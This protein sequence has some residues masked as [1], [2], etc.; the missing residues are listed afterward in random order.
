MRD[1]P[2]SNTSDQQTTS[3][4]R[5]LAPTPMSSPPPT[6]PSAPTPRAAKRSLTTDA[7][8]SPTAKRQK[9]QNKVSNTLP[10]S[11]GKFK[12][13][14][15]RKHSSLLHGTRSDGAEKPRGLIVTCPVGAETRALGQ[16]RTFLDTYL[17]ILFPDHVTVWPSQP[18]PLDIDLAIV[19]EGT[20]RPDFYG[21]VENSKSDVRTGEV[22]TDADEDEVE[23]ER[24]ADDADRTV[25]EGKGKEREKDKKFQAVD[26][27]CAGL[28]F[29]RFRVDTDPVDFVVRLFEHIES[30]PPAEQAALKKGISHCS[31]L[32]PVTHTMPSTYPD[33]RSHLQSTLPTLLAAHQ[34]PQSSP[35]TIPTLAVI[36]EIRNHN[37]FKTVALRDV[38]LECVGADALAS[39]SKTEATEEGAQQPTSGHWKISLTNPDV[40]IFA[41]VFKS[42][43]GVAVLP[44]YFAWRRYNV[45]LIGEEKVRDVKDGGKEGAGK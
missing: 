2:L 37:T 25:I 5:T 18:A 32:L 3:K 16:I 22:D 41:N 23:D 7:P 36:S 21:A 27:A 11:R 35:P 31:R 9:K 30:L 15:L 14:F 6:R 26:A 42:V 43:C 8:T 34:P 28:I 44:R 29:I 12:N 4:T 13:R 40:V 24:R 39:E 1:L 10:I 38:I 33:I 45:Q 17:P 20:T 19:G